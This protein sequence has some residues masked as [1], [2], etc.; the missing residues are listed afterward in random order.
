MGVSGHHHNKPPIIATFINP[1]RLI[2]GIRVRVRARV[3]R[4]A[5]NLSDLHPKCL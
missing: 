2:I 3:K 4:F 1:I 5:Y